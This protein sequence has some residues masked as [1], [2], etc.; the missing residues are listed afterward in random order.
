MTIEFTPSGLSIS[1]LTE[2]IER[3][4][5]E[6]KSIYGVDINLESSTPDGQRIGIE[7][8]VIADTEEFVLNLYNQMDPDLAEGQWLDKLIKFSGIV[9]KAATR[10]TVD[11]EVTT[12]RNL[13]LPINYTIT[14][15]LNQEWITTSESNLISGVNTVTFVSKVFGSIAA[16]ANT[17][18]NPTE[19]ILGVVSVNNP[20]NAIIG[21]DEETDGELRIRR[22]KSVERPAFS[23]VGGLFARLADLDGV[24]DLSILENDTNIYDATNDLNAHTIWCI[25]EGGEVNDIIEVITKNR[26]AGV[27]TKGSISGVFIETLTLPNGDPFTIE[28]TMNFDRPNIVD[29]YVS[30]TAT[31][32][33]IASPIDIDLIKNKLSERLFTIGE[34]VRA[35]A[36][37]SIAYQA[38]TNF[39]LSD[40]LISDDDVVFTDEN[41]IAGAGDKFRIQVA[42]IDVTE[43]I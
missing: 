30:L 21:I 28:H 23:T 40:L 29:L 3:L 16:D 33:N 13:T 35:S 20:S 17:I 25:V 31:R 22:A 34:N 37:Y 15:D 5:A 39:V 43:V 6:Y 4:Q 10:S 36:L 1:T 12:D 11:I 26:T 8:K 18:N 7:A 42:N 32:T 14:D 19:V 38:G 27:G 2:I 41:I 24:S 9:R